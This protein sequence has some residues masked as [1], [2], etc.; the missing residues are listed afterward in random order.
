MGRIRF[1]RQCL[2]DDALRYSIVS[3]SSFLRSI[4]FHS[5]YI[6]LVLFRLQQ[7]VTRTDK[8]FFARILSLLNFRISG[9]EFIPGCSVGS[10]AFLPHPSGIVIGRNVIIG[11]ECTIMQNVTVGQN[12]F[13]SSLASNKS[14]QI[15]D[16]V[17]IGAGSIILGDISIG[18][19]S[20]IGALSLVIESCPPGSLILGSKATSR[21]WVLR[22]SNPR[23][24]D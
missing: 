12:S 17:Q 21:E 4:L 9:C 23:P 8:S 3:F 19:G 2:R 15:G 7:L 24:G 5:G 18:D 1:F 13:S 14:P 22:D 11:R 6:A 10:G 16:R 20:T